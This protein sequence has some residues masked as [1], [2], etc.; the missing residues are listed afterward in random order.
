MTTKILVDLGAQSA[1]FRAVIVSLMIFDIFLPATLTLPCARPSQSVDI[2]N[3]TPHTD[4]DI[5]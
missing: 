4:T 1:S 2:S 3:V 5:A